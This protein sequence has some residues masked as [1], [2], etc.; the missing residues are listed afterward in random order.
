MQGEKYSR[1]SEGQSGGGVGQHNRRT[2][3]WTFDRSSR[4]SRLQPFA[5]SLSLLGRALSL[6]IQPIRVIAIRPLATET[7]AGRSRKIKLFCEL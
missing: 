5:R 1:R 6:A 2:C 7:E 3:H 4:Q